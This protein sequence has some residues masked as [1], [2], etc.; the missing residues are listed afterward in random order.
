MEFENGWH[1]SIPGPRFLDFA[2]RYTY[3]SF[4]PIFHGVKGN[5]LGINSLQG[6]LGANWPFWSS[7]RAPQGC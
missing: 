7:P 3:C 6:L 2:L 4:P 1:A 5:I